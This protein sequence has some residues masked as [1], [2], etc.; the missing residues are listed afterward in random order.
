MRRTR[1]I[2]AAV[3][4]FALAGCVG[5]A[6]TGGSVVEVLPEVD[7]H[8]ACGNEVLEL[9]DGRDFYP[10]LDQQDVDPAL[11][12]EQATAP[13][14]L[15]ASIVLTAP[16]PGDIPGDDVGT[17][18]VFD[19]GIARFESSIGTVAWLTEDEVTYGFVC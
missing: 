7:Y 3:L 2:S 18:T 5:T 14:A 13:R 6:A 9:P 10:L 11:Y 4:A 8:Y 15:V 1:T 12:Q 16:A 17:L 19:D